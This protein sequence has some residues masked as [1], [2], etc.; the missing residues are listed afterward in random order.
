M[1]TLIKG[2]RNSLLI[3]V[4]YLVKFA[5]LL[6]PKNNKLIL[7]GSMSGKY[8]G[9][10]SSHLFEWVVNHRPEVEATWAT[11]NKSDFK[12]LKNNGFN[13]VF[14]RSISGVL[15]LLR[16]KV[17]CFTNSLQDFAFSM[18][19]VPSNLKVI[20]LTHDIAPK[21]SR[22]SREGHK[23]SPEQIKRSKI[24][25]KLV[26]DYI[27]TSD[28][29]TKCRAEA[30]DVEIDKFTITGLPRN[31]ALLDKNRKSNSLRIELGNPKAIV[32]Y[33]PTWRSGR[34]STTLFPFEDF[35]KQKLIELLNEH[36]ISLVVRCHK[37]DLKYEDVQKKIRWLSEGNNRI[38]DGTHGMFSDANLLLS[39]TDVLVT[40]YSGIYHDFLL[41]DKPLIFIPYDYEEFNKM[42]GFYYDYFEMAPGH[43]VTSFSLF[44]NA[45]SSI[46][47]GN[48]QYRQ[49]RLTLR[50]MIH[51]Y[52]DTYSS[53]RVYDLLI[54]QYINI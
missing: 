19:A 44:T 24:E 30:L 6:I 3:M 37:N 13:V 47:N 54:R 27:S 16:A 14:I 9:D 41:I 4:C 48:D 50:N 31:D 52:Q 8:Y 40:D 49:K 18:H 20:Y 38:F 7:L 34:N 17:A 51:T 33:A 26:N 15:A 43:I 29:I 12:R 23:L 28:F 45:I 11:N 5:S 39:E 25:R 1:T 42:N 21:K 22:H 2:I 46:S 53:K 36:D 35:S 10:N 32:L